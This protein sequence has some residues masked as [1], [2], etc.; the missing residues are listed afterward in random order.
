MKRGEFKIL[1]RSGSARTG[2]FATEHGEFSTP[3]FMPIA[4]QGSVK[5]VNPTHLKSLGAE[6]ILTNTYHLHLRPGEELIASLGGFH[7]FMAWDGPVL[8]DSGGFQVFSLAKLR[9]ITDSGVE[10]R[11]HHD[12]RLVEFTPESVVK[13]QETLGVDIMMVLDECVALPASREV[14]ERSI[15]RTLGWADRS[16]EARKREQSLLFG[17]VQGGGYADLREC[18]ALELTKR[19]FDGFAIGGLSVGEPAMVMDEMTRVCCANLPE[20][21]IRYLMG[22]GTPSDIVQSVLLGVDLFDCV[23]PTRC[24]RFGRL[25]TEEMF[26]NIRNHEFRHDPRPIDASCH[27][28]T[29]RTFSRAYLS[30]LI[31]SKEALAVE[32]ASVH[33]LYFYQNLMKRI[34]SA[35]AE[36]KFLSFAEEFL[37]RRAGERSEEL[38]R[39]ESIC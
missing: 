9:R 29:C 17:I 11:S 23:I 30:H 6:I 26:I 19:N 24:A 22:V 39:I 8:S 32:L 20:E 12:G 35:I 14:I 7:K 5:G 27:C 3:A 28:Y 38:S 18:A 10:F 33:N 36:N 1:A 34:R 15:E 13:T 4:T 31:H 21:K 37:H 2:R 25:Y 16:I